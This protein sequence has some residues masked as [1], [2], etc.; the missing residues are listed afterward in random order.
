MLVLALFA[1]VHINAVQVGL[2]RMLV[3]CVATNI[4]TLLLLT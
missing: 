4:S 1:C 2:Y 3:Q